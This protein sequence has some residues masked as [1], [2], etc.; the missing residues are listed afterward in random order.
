MHVRRSEIT[1]ADAA[2]TRRLCH[3]P[4]RQVAPERRVQPADATAARRPRLR[5]LVLH[6][7]QR[8]AEPSQ[9]GQLRPQRPA[10][11]A[12]SR[13]IRPTWSPT[14]PSAGSTAAATG[15]ALLP[16]RLLPRA[17]RAHRL[18]RQVREALSVRRPQLQRTSRQHHPDGRRLRPTDARDRRAGAAREHVRVLHQRQRPR[19]HGEHPHGSAGP[20]RDKK[21]SLYEGG[22]RVPGILRWPGRD[23]ARQR[24]RRAGVRRGLPADGVRHRRHRPAPRPRARRRELPAGARRPTRRAQ[25]AA[26]L[27]LQ[28]RHQ[29]G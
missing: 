1:V 29:R 4:Q 12:S 8:A 17:A 28:P 14:R 26:V 7:E 2:E 13:A 24:E 16:L 21:G 19:H 11:R 15:E 6:A 25:H 22:I 27:A 20:L 5:P 10:G 9:S 18:R 23:Q 3:L